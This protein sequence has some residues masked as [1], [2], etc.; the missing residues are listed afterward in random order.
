MVTSFAGEGRWEAH[1]VGCWQG[2]S[3]STHIVDQVLAQVGYRGEVFLGPISGNFPHI[4]RVPLKGVVLIGP[5]A[6]RLDF[7]ICLRPRSE[8]NGCRLAAIDPWLGTVK[9]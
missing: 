1:G 2:D 4:E 8:P 7:E 9:V 6:Q 5:A 3:A